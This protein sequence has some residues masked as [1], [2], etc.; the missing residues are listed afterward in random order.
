M[1]NTYK[2]LEAVLKGGKKAELFL[3]L[4]KGQKVVIVESPRKREAYLVDGD[5]RALLVEKMK[6]IA[7]TISDWT[8]LQ[9][10]LRRVEEKYPQGVRI[11]EKP[12]Y[13]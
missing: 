2:N 3:R 4:P 13:F 10:W 5:A 9:M 1:N 8:R 7:S 12:Q 6:R 11:M